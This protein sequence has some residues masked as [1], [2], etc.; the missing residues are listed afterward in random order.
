MSHMNDMNDMDDMDD[1][2]N[3]EGMMIQRNREKGNQAGQIEIDG[4]EGERDLRLGTRK[5]K[6]AVIVL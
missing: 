6:S 4:K 1:D 2:I 3:D 5:E